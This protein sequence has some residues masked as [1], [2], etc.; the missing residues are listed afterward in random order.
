MISLSP[1]MIYE[2]CRF[3]LI[4][5]WIVASFSCRFRFKLQFSSWMLE[6]NPFSILSF[7]N[8]SFS[9]P[10]DCP[11]TDSLPVLLISFILD[12]SS[13]YYSLISSCRLLYYLA[14]CLPCLKLY[15]YSWFFQ[16]KVMSLSDWFRES[17]SEGSEQSAPR[18]NSLMI[19]LVSSLL[20][21]QELQML[22]SFCRSFSDAILDSWRWEACEKFILI[23]IE[24]TINCY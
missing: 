8:S 2:S 24:T 20:R 13:S 11:S 3:I 23:F 22:M 21:P 19:W 9:N 18:L 12:Y 7:S 17:L 10:F 5:S 16:L 14:F 1:R 15:Y 6:I 4:R